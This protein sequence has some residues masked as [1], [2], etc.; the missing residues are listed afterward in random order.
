MTIQL[1][2]NNLLCS[3]DRTNW[4]YSEDGVNKGHPANAAFDADTGTVT[5]TLSPA[6]S[7]EKKVPG[8]NRLVEGGTKVRVTYRPSN[9]VSNRIKDQAGEQLAGFA[10]SLLRWYIPVSACTKGPGVDPRNP[11]SPCNPGPDE[12]PENYKN[13]DELNAA[14]LNDP[15]EPR[16]VRFDCAGGTPNQCLII[17]EH[18][19]PGTQFFTFRI[20][21]FADLEQDPADTANTCTARNVVVRKFSGQSN[22]TT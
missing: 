15:P 13:I 21:L 8:Q 9:T 4:T 3:A 22:S 17:W 2:E 19:A 18:P 12:R 1:S 14:E 20:F 10:N 7:V 11:D 6:V 16:N 5:L